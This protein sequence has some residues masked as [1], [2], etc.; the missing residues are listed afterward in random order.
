MRK[1]RQQEAQ[2]WQG[3]ASDVDRGQFRT[4]EKELNRILTLPEG[5]IRRDDAQKY[6]RQVI[7]QRMHEEALLTQARQAAQKNDQNS[8]PM[9]RV[10]STRSS[11]WRAQENPTLSSYGSKFQPSW[12][13]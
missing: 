9:P 7:P 6:L 5:G 10:C 1:L 2:L 8:L 11:H 4:A 13:T 3:A 12:R